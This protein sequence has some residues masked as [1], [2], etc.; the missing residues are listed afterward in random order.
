[1][2]NEQRKSKEGILVSHNKFHFDTRS[3]DIKTPYKPKLG[4]IV[5]TIS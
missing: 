3:Y 4:R 5:T 1:V 2:K